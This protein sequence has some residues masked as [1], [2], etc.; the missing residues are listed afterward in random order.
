MRMTDGF[1]RIRLE[2]PLVWLALALT[3]LG[4]GA[5]PEEL[6]WTV[7]ADEAPLRATPSME[8]EPVGML[9]QGAEVSGEVFIDDT[10][11]VE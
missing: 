8:A 2:R 7:A 11:G 10:N 1:F 3:C 9:A 6:P 4:L 5:Q